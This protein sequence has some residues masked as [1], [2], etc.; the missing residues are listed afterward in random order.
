MDNQIIEYKRPII[1]MI[2]DVVYLLIFLP[3]CYLGILM[4][5]LN[6]SKIDFRNIIPPSESDIYVFVFLSLVAIGAIRF[7]KEVLSIFLC[8]AFFDGNKAIL[9]MPFKT[10]IL[11][12]DFIEDIRLQLQSRP[13]FR[14][15]RRYAL[16]LDLKDGTTIEF[17]NFYWSNEKFDEILSE[18]DSPYTEDSNIEDMP[19]IDS[20]VK[21]TAFLN[22]ELEENGVFEMRENIKL[23]LFIL[24]SILLFA[25][26]IGNILFMYV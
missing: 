17:G 1:T 2:S 6:F 7:G 12:K 22:A 20:E 19:A 24:H 8:D 10:Y 15:Y 13:V 23:I 21:E 14:T 11:R 25:G 5:A 4:P 9:Q 3:F 18:L 26:I 16:L